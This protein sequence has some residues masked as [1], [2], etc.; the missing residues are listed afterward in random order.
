MPPPPPPPP[1]P[2]H[3]HTHQLSLVPVVL[4]VHCEYS[5]LIPFSKCQNGESIKTLALWF[6]FS[7][8]VEK[9][10]EKGFSFIPVRSLSPLLSL[11]P[12]SLLSAA[13]SL[14]IPASFYSIYSYSTVN[15]FL[16]KREWV[17][18][19][20]GKAERNPEIA[21]GSGIFFSCSYPSAFEPAMWKSARSTALHSSLPLIKSRQS[22]LNQHAK[23]HST[24]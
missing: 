7:P 8:P 2:T 23:C 15:H 22:G 16:K 6:Y 12:I 19:R 10:Q 3:T 20:G 17:R 11:P 1:L 21:D 14:S 9:V 18:V 13:L 5:T 24:L 4:S